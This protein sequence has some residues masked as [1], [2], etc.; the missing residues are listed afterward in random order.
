[1][2]RVQAFSLVVVPTHAFYLSYDLDVLSQ[3]HVSKLSVGTK[4][5]IS[6]SGIYVCSFRTS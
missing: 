3:Y 1:M 5:V 6:S 2:V 4:V